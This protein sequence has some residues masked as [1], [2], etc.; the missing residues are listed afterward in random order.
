[1]VLVFNHNQ[2]QHRF[3]AEDSEQV[4]SMLPISGLRYTT[5]CDKNAAG[6][7]E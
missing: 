2:L 7:A 3:E 5:L 6:S 1:L 4:G